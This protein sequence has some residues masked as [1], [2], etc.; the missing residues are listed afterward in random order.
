MHRH[1]F[2]GLSGY[3]CVTKNMIPLEDR[4]PATCPSQIFVR[5]EI[6]DKFA[7]A[8]QAGIM[9][10]TLGNLNRYDI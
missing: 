6:I 7:C 2:V 8:C 1:G 4:K 10:K 3:A 9:M 5:S